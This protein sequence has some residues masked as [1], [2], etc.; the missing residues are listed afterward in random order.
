MRGMISIAVCSA[1][2]LTLLLGC[3]SLNTGLSGKEKLEATDW[4]HTGDLA[5]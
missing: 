5:Y 1:V 2:A 4:L 3:A